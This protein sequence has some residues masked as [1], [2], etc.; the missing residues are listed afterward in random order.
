MSSPFKISPSLLKSYV[1]CPRNFQITKFYLKEKNIPKRNPSR[2]AVLGRFAH[3]SFYYKYRDILGGFDWNPNLDEFIAF[4][5][6]EHKFLEL[7]YKKDVLTERDFLFDLEKNLLLQSFE[8]LLKVRN[9]IRIKEV[10][11]WEERLEGSIDG[12]NNIVFEIIPDLVFITERGNYVLLDIKNRKNSESQKISYI[13]YSEV[14]KNKFGVN[15]H[16]LSID[17]IERKIF[18][19]D[20]EALPYKN[21]IFSQLHM[22]EKSLMTNIYPQKTKNCVECRVRSLCRTLPSQI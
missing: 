12:I 11:V 19:H 8:F 13:I 16:T 22:L 10:L 18:K 6:K 14:L 17:V 5:N 2:N 21:Y 4:L 3:A 1:F 20:L 7:L 15:F 9:S